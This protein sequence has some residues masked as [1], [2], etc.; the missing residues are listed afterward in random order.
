MN[1]QLKPQALYAR[2]TSATV[3][4]EI[5]P[6]LAA[7]WREITHYPDIALD[8]DYERFLAAEKRGALRIFTAR[9]NGELAGYAIFLVGPSS[10][11]KQS[12]QALQDVLYL[13]PEYRRGRIG[14]HLIKFADD[15][16]RAEGVQVS[17]QHVKAAHDFGPL[18]ARLGYEL[19]DL[20]YSRRLDR[21]T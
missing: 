11:S 8:V 5:K 13:D 19:V 14:M 9:N 2:E 17:I 7:H 18:L 12:I 4:D 3:L 20:V 10:R 15:A 1:A 6:L 16:L 21:G